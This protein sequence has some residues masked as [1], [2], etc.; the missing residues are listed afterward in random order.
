MESSY[1]GGQAAALLLSKR[2]FPFSHFPPGLF[3]EWQPDRLSRK[4]K[5]HPQLSLKSITTGKIDLFVF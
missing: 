4:A 1:C 5:E 3:S 2:G